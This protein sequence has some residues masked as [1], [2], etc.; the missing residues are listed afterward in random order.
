[1]AGKKPTYDVFISHSAKDTSLAEG[2][3]ET[4][5]AHGLQP[6]T[7]FNLPLGTNIEEALWQAMAESQ[8]LVVVISTPEPSANIG[9]EIGAALA[10]GKPIYVIV[11]DPATTQL[12]RMVLG[13]PGVQLYPPSRIDEVAEQIKQA[14]DDFTA[15]E[16]KELIKEYRNIGLSVDRLALDSGRLS[17]LARNFHKRTKRQVPGER[18]LW[19][20]L[21]LRK[22]RVLP[23]IKKAKGTSGKSAQQG[24]K[25][26]KAET[27][28]G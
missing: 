8:A 1:M 17:E 10:W 2:I 19:L 11:T 20:L 12:S 16:I 27:L 25:G 15:E 28:S 14:Q 7:P 3:A 23:A 22:H 9:F 6:F 13:A 18:L 26:I 21:R 24:R 5:Q 4:L